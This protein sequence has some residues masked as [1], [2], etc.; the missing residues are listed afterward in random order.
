MILYPANQA[1]QP[2]GKFTF[3]VCFTTLVLILL[4]SL[5]AK[6]HIIDTHA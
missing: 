2:L 6:Y 4:I 3:G 1:T 5:N